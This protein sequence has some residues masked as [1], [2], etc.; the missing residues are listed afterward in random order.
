MK[1]AFDGMDT[2]LMKL[3]SGIPERELVFAAL[4]L[5]SD[6]LKSLSPEEKMVVIGEKIN[7]LGSDAA[8]N[9]SIPH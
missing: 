4:N 2:S 1:D 5:K 8:K 7:E 6:N 3:N 9:T